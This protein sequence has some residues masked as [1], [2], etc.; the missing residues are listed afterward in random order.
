[1]KSK[2]MNMT[3]GNPVRL[4]LVFSV[5]MLI[6]NVFQQLYNLVDSMIVGRYV[7][8]DALA[9]IGATNSVGFLFWAICN[10]LGSG[11]GILTAREFGAGNDEDVRKSIVNSGYILI[12]GSL[13]MGIIAAVVS[14]P[15]L[16]FMN[17]P[18]H[19][20]HDTLVYMY[21]QCIGLPLVAIYNHVSC[22]LRALGD[23]KTPL[24]FLIFAALLNVVLDLW[25]VCG[26]G[27]G[28]F[29]AA[30]ATG[31]AQIIAGIGC[32][33]YAIKYNAYFKMKPHHFKPEGKILWECVRLGVP[34]SVQFSMI[35]VSCMALQRV[36]NGYGSAV[37]AAFTATS[38]VE[39]L[40][41]QPYQTL[42][43]A[44]S[45]YSGQN[46]GAKE[47]DRIRL[48]FRKSM[49]MMGIFS[50]VMLPVMQFG[51]EAI[52]ELFV[53]DPVVIHYGAKAMMITSWFYITLGTIYMTR[54]VLNGIGDAA[55]ALI[56]GIVEVVGRIF[57]PVAL[58]MIPFIGV[59]GIWWSTGI[60]WLISAVF[61]YLRYVS[62]CKKLKE[63][64]LNDN[65]EAVTG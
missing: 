24:Y 45:T 2:V 53:D 40:L 10:G 63:P 44:L 31:I 15:V 20:M 60:V 59:W 35:A 16:E 38:R 46:L 64:Q 13:V 32:L 51:G 58:T 61:C 50:L 55:F 14:E 41:H 57:V 4:L 11:G 5:P 1:M 27:W 48:G 42:S 19:I 62:W 18:Q 56:N 22:M 52:I 37:M 12:L 65:G 23:S 3:T 39:Q 8:E 7:G 43:A 54:G 33:I 34:L 28:V 17:T 9:A 21:M 26:F 47:H 29:G 49:L 30:L 6:G 36:V 25:F